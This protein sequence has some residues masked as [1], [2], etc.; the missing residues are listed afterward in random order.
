[1]VPKKLRDEIK[2]LA[3]ATG[4]DKSTLMRKLMFKGLEEVK[5]DIGVDSYV[6]GKTSLEK[7]SQLAGVSIWRFLDELTNR[8]I[9]IRYKLEDAQEE[10]ARIIARRKAV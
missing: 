7:S 6:K 9:G 8:K 10:I 3:A 2:S 4:E 5:L 1:V